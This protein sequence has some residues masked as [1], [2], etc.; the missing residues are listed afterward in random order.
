MTLVSTTKS[1]VFVQGEDH[2]GPLRSWIALFCAKIP[3]DVYGC[4]VV[5]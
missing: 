1:F 2:V 5:R 3:D 4:D